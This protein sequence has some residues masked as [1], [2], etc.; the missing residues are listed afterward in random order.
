MKTNHKNFINLAFNIAKINLGNTNLNPSVGCVIVKNNSVISTGYTSINGRPHAEINALQP[1]INFK[2]SDLYVT[3]EP[4]THYGKTPPCV[5]EIKKK[6]VKRVFFSFKDIDK[7]TA[8]KSKKILL[9]SNVKVVK[10]DVKKFKNFYESYYLSKNNKRPL[11]D[12]KIA[13][14]DDF[15]TINKKDKW[16]T[17]S[18]SRKRVHLIRSQYDT[19]ISTSKSI[20]ED[21]SILNCRLNGFNP[22]KPNVIIIDLKLKIKIN[23]NIFTNSNKRKIFIV[24]S[25]TNKKRLSAFKKLG[26]K[27]I[28]I[29]SLKD[30]NDFNNLLDLFKKK[31]FTRILVESGLTF[32]NQLLKNKI[33]H[34][35]FIFKSNKKL[36]KNGSNNASNIL[37][38]KLNFNNKIKVNLRGETLYKLKIK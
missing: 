2:N 26:I 12:A 35:L 3:M 22:Y 21:N 32:L 23:L 25:I 8:G 30:K 29:K 13:I 16:I 31:S 1:K 17:N 37:I 7:R 28:K 36:N 4:C 33:I 24:T 5:N 38:K 19:I 18:Y 34:N 27:I 11:I 20:N 15:F 10:K 14:S 6:G 9:D